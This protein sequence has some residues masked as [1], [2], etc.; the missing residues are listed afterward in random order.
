MAMFYKF[1]NEQPGCTCVGNETRLRRETSYKKLNVKIL[2]LEEGGPQFH[3]L[4]PHEF[5]EKASGP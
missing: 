2:L 4:H 1:L 3:S 5:S